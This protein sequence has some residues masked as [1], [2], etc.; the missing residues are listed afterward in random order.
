MIRLAPVI[1]FVAVI[2]L[3]A[4]SPVIHFATKEDVTFAVK[5][6]E[7]VTTGTG[8]NVDSKYLIFTETETFENTDSFL[9]FKFNSSD[10]YGDIDE[11]DTCAATVTGFRVPFLSMYRNVLAV[12]CEGGQA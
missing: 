11:G 10:I 7:R 12:A 4:A 6:T 9:A 8:S 5:R 1:G 3:V 2:G